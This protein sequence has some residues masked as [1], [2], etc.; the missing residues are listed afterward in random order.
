[1]P[2]LVHET[3]EGTFEGHFEVNAKPF[4][5]TLS[6]TDLSVTLSITDSA[7][8]TLFKKSLPRRD[9]DTGKQKLLSQ[10]LEDGTEPFKS[11]LYDEGFAGFEI[12]PEN[13]EQ[14]FVNA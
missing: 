7:N 3:T 10:V 6:A 5:L 9:E 1:M 14:A 13:T 11:Y 4:K 2:V 12:Q 8:S